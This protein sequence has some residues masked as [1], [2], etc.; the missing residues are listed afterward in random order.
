MAHYC[1]LRR[2]LPIAGVVDVKSLQG[3]A[4][5]VGA[6]L[7]KGFEVGALWWGEVG[8][9]QKAGDLSHDDEVEKVRGGSAKSGRCY[10]TLE[11]Q[12]VE[13]T[14]LQQPQANIPYSQSSLFRRLS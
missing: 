13:E 2:L 9:L 8:G 1:L 12:R 14:F 4:V 5:K 11:N 6:R 3:G 10:Y 7:S